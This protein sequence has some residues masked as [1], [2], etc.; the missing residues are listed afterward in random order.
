MLSKS[1]RWLAGCAVLF[2]LAWAAAAGAAD[3][4]VPVSPVD[5]EVSA[6]VVVDVT[7]RQPGQPALV[8]LV[9]QRDLAQRRFGRRDEQRPA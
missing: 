1:I 8:G 9:E 5:E 7:A 6:Q 4:R 2:V 3:V